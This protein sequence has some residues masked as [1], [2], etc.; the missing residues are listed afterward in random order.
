[1]IINK[2]FFHNK[3]IENLRDGGEGDLCALTYAQRHLRPDFCA[4]TFAPPK[5]A[6][7]HLRIRLVRPFPF[8]K[9]LTFFERYFTSR[10]AIISAHMLERKCSCAIIERKY[11]GA[12]VEALYVGAQRSFCNY[13]VQMSGYICQGAIISAHK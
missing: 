9:F 2:G 12:N 4:P 10:G 13:R 5:F 8:L 3:N 7:Q 6:P 11:R 1:M